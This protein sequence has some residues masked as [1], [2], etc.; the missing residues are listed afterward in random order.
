MNP[1]GQLNYAK[2]TAETIRLQTTVKTSPSQR[3][4]IPPSKEA[5]FLKALGG[6]QPN[7]QG[8]AKTQ[9]QTNAL[10]GEEDVPKHFNETPSTEA[11]GHKAG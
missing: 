1:S 3:E 11:N 9:L 5:V 8:N 2:Q 6:Q 4:V 7:T 10:R